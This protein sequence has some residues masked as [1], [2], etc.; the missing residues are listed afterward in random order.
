M[1]LKNWIEKL[2]PLKEK[3]EWDSYSVA[4]TYNKEQERQKTNIVKDFSKKNKPN[5]MADIGCNDGHYSFESLKSGCKKVIG[6]DIDINSID[7]AYKKSLKLGYDFLPLYFNATNPS[8]R[9]GWFEKER[10]SFIDRLNFDAV[11]A[12]AFE[13]HLALA[14]NVPLED[15]VKWI[16]KIAKKGLVEFVDKTDETVVRMLSLKGDIFPNY[17]QENF[18]KYILSNGKIINKSI[19][20]NTRIL[21]EFETK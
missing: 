15:V 11:I 18:E 12:L 1:Q 2:N 8:A 19:I 3:T 13:H 9:L 17:N 16:M 14:N 21:Y 20:S 5:L 10:D 7:R 4:N 6:F